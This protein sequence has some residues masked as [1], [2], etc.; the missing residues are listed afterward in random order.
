MG[1]HLVT[2]QEDREDLVD[3]VEQRELAKADE[4]LVSWLGLDNLEPWDRSELNEMRRRLDHDPSWI[5]CHLIGHDF[6]GFDCQ[7]CALNVE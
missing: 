2:K 7:R 1:L 6:A 4:V 3:L 5:I